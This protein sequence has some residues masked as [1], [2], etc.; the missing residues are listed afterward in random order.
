VKAMSESTALLNEAA[1][2]VGKKT[3]NP[4]SIYVNYAA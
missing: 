4:A 3:I 1:K 2:A